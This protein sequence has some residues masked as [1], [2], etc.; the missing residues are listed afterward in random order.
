MK[1]FTKSDFGSVINCDSE[2]VTDLNARTIVTIQVL[3]CE[4]GTLADHVA[5][6]GGGLGM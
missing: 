5:V 6:A 1:K 2:D 4:S 3:K